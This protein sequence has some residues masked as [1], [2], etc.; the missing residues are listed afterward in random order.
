MLRFL[1]ANGEKYSIMI[2]LWPRGQAVK[3]PPSH[4]GYR[5]SNPLGV[6]RNAFDK[7]NAQ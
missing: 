7:S 2:K 5:G 3:T 1:L 4:G 6:T